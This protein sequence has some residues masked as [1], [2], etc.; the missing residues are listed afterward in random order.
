MLM[1]SAL[2][3]LLA[4]LVKGVLGMGLPT[5]AMGLLA[6]VMTPAEAAAQLLIP[7][8]LTNLWQLF[9]GPA[10]A[11]L[12]R[13]LW[14][15]LAGICVGTLLGARWLVG[16]DA[17]WIAG[18]LGA[19]LACYGLLGLSARRFGV[20][21]RQEVWLSPLV[22]LATG[23]VT[24]ATGVFVIPAVPYLQALRLD[25]E[26]LIQALGL[27]FSVSTL[28]LGAGLLHHGALQAT[29]LGRSLVML[30]PA[31]LG[32]GL[33]QWLRHRLSE[34]LFRRLFFIGLIV[35]GIHLIIEALLP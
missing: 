2:V 28:A 22:G 5:V 8:M 25:K 31:M 6:L 27:S 4:G 24:G 20:P 9:A 14:P 13:R 16:S 29:D 26:D 12:L 11:G 7:S 15:M 3:F 33:G 19:M 10:L 32:L 30:A 35:L 1:F 34:A 21:P 23:L 18:A 17:G